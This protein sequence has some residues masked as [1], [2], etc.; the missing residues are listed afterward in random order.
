MSRPI[1][2][3]FVH[4]RSELGGAP[5]SLSYLIRELDRDRYEPHV[6]C[7]RGPA[8]ELFRSVGAT[9]HTGP[10]ATFTHIWASTYSGR[11]WLLFGHELARLPAHVAAFSRVLH[12]QRFGIVH[13][14]DSPLVA[15]AALARR[16]GIPVVWHLRS[17]LPD[18][19]GEVRSRLLRAAIGRLANASIAIT[20]EIARSFDVGSIVIPNTVDLDVFHPTDDPQ[21]RSDLGLADGL[22]VVSYF[23]FLYPMKGFR[24]FIDAA[25]LLTRQGVEAHYLIVGGPVRGEEFFSTRFGRAL[26]ALGLARDHQHEAEELVEEQGLGDQVRF[27]PFTRETARIFQATDVVVAPSRGPELGR[28]VLEAA[29]S[30]RAIVASGST[31]G[32]GILL[33]DETG[34]LIPRWSHDTLAAAL[35][36]LLADAELRQRL[37]G[38]ARRLAEQQFDAA[39]NAARVM[40][41]YDHLL[42]Q[43]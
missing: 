39:A 40:D 29:A 27:V 21:A 17:S 2:V 37:G 24:E 28:P 32:A 10:V 43:R 33:P 1:P 36:R 15:A 5:T 42:E 3:L 31:D 14:N 9:V 35:A 22:P 19:G 7:P 4:H 6:Y 41:L 25:G 12:C 16:A 18:N 11:R 23:G 13:V 38:N 30:G 20:T 34:L 26:S 8:A